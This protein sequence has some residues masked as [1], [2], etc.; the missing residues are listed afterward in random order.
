MAK[1]STGDFVVD[2]KSYVI[3]FNQKRIDLYERVSTPIMA[4]FSKNGGALS[5]SELKHLTAYGLRLEDGPF[6]NPKS[7]LEMAEKLIEENGYFPV[8]EIVIEALQRD[9]GFLFAGMGD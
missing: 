2:G 8:Y 9:C 5:L 4:S 3:A 6:V 1:E 7:G